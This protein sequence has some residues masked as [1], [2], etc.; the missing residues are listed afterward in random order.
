MHDR[1]KM[2]GL[3]MTFLAMVFFI[4]A[5][6]VPRLIAD[7]INDPTTIDIRDDEATVYIHLGWPLNDG[8]DT[9]CEQAM[10][11]YHHFTSQGYTVRLS[12]NN[13]FIASYKPVLTLNDTEC[14]VDPH[15]NGWREL[16]VEARAFNHED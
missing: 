11:L 1:I 10:E 3:G 9:H 6:A 4:T 7:V 2:I 14:L 15:C 8:T 5:I 13:G 12:S 16:Q